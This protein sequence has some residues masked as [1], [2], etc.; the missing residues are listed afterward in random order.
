MVGA[1]RR[2]C[3]QGMGATISRSLWDIIVSGLKSVDSFINSQ[4]LPSLS[5]S[6]RIQDMIISD[7]YC[8][9]NGFVRGLDQNM[10]A[11]LS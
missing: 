1:T 5:K 6:R 8:I 2:Y 3:W 4:Q 7:V 9:F 11:L 10:K